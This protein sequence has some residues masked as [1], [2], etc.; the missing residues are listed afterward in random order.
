MTA[1]RPTTRFHHPRAHRP[2]AIPAACRASLCRVVAREPGG[3]FELNDERVERAVLMVRGAEIA[4]AR[5]RLALNALQQLCRKAR[6]ADAR[7][8]GEQ[9]HA[10]F[11]ALRLLPAAKKQFDFLLAP[12]ERRRPLERSASK[13]LNRPL[14]PTP[15][16]ARCGS[17][18]PL[19]PLRPEVLQLEQIAEQLAACSRR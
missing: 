3:A 13:R 15:R 14:S 16:Q 10:P 5:V 7:L 2:R 6:F 9:H 12:D 11:A 1:A 19:S 17:A 18:K 4:Q 8:A